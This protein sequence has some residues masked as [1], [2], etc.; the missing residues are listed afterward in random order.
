MWGIKYWEGQ[1]GNKVERI[2]GV[3]KRG[4]WQYDPTDK[5]YTNSPIA[6]D[7][8]VKVNDIGKV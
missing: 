6:L 8:G 1:R 5:K 4:M 7:N 2:K 3:L